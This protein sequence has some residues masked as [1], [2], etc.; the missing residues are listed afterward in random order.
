VSIRLA[1]FDLS[2]GVKAYRSLARLEQLERLENPDGKYLSGIWSTHPDTDERFARL[3]A[4]IESP[5]SGA[6][7]HQSLASRSCG[8]ELLDRLDR[9]LLSGNPEPTFVDEDGLIYLLNLFLQ[10]T[11][12][13]EHGAT[14]E[15]GWLYLDGVHQIGS[16]NRVDPG[17]TIEWAVRRVSELAADSKLILRDTSQ[18]HGRP[19][20]RAAWHSDGRARGRVELRHWIEIDGRVYR[21]SSEMPF[22]S[23]AAADPRLLAL[24]AHIEPLDPDGVPR[25]ALQ[26][27]S[28]IHEVVVGDTRESI[29]E[30]YPDWDVKELGLWNGLE[31]DHPL[32]PGSRLKIMNRVPPRID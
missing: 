24:A 28:E 20:V 6:A 12:S 1:G 11:P 10:I 31:P 25:E 2:C 13:D 21:I 22:A 15:N 19:S 8:T 17:E 3:A 5:S 30:Q 29:A 16:L 32:T 9:V 4:T 27:R 23:W 18:D 26:L 7:E 14:Y